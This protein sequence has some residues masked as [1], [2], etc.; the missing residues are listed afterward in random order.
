LI[1]RLPTLSA[2]GGSDGST[3][4]SR[5][6]PRGRTPSLHH[7]R[8][9]TQGLLATGR[10]DGRRQRP[11]VISSPAPMVDGWSTSSRRPLS[12][13]VMTGRWVWRD[14]RQFVAR[15]SGGRRLLRPLRR[16]GK[17]TLM[18]SVARSR[19][20]RY[21]RV[22]AA[23]PPLLRANWT[24]KAAGCRTRHSTQRDEGRDHD[25]AVAG[26]V[27]PEFADASE[28]RQAPL[29]AHEW[30]RAGAPAGGTTLSGS[31]SAND[32]DRQRDPGRGR[33]R[34]GGGRAFWRATW[35]RAAPGASDRAGPAPLAARC[36]APPGRAGRGRGRAGSQVA[37]GPAPRGEAPSGGR[38]PGALP[39]ERG[40]RGLSR[41]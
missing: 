35:R 40:L 36:E 24:A 9:A 31:G 8:T 3:A 14:S 10:G 23:T 18:G 26:V 17:P 15:D 19:I 20:A 13:A 32:G 6:R 11:P 21:A 38:A 16:L 22:W 7:A 30:W 5:S 1:R 12:R 4:R 27:E 2:D 33:G 28:S 34:P 39:G 29:R 25:A 37:P 41:G